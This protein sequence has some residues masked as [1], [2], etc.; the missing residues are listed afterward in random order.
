[1]RQ[2]C[3]REDANI[4]QRA[5]LPNKTYEHSTRSNL[6]F[7]LNLRSSNIQMA[8][9]VT[10]QCRNAATRSRFPSGKLQPWRKCTESKLRT[11][12][13]RLFLSANKCHLDTQR[14]RQKASQSTSQWLNKCVQNSDHVYDY[15]VLVISKK[16]TKWKQSYKCQVSKRECVS[17]H[18]TCGFT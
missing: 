5:R 2:V 8:Q 17:I 11:P 13:S 4:P 16:C 1:M 10:C 15:G 18:C 14:A 3:W 6:K 9:R 7:E 12:V